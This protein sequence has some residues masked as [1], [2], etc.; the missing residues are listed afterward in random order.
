MKQSSHKY[1]EE[2]RTKQQSAWSKWTF[3]GDIISGFAI[4]KNFYLMIDR[5]DAISEEDWI[6]GTGQWLM[7]KVWKMDGSWIMSPDSFAKFKQFERLAIQPKDEGGVFLDNR[8]TPIDGR[9][10][11]GEWVYGKDGNK[12]ER[13]TLQ[14]KTVEVTASEDSALK[15]TVEDTQRKTYRE[16]LDKQRKGRKPMVYGN[17]SRIRV[18]LRNE[19]DRGFR[20]EM[21]SFEGNIN[22]RAKSH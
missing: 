17:S 7:D 4:S 8:A 14:M 19:G 2:G 20:V 10:D 22:K 5:N 11:L 18:G 6:M 13:G 9:I 21:V 15:I 3:D 12:D 1:H 16:I